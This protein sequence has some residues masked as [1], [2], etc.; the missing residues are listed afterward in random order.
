MYI[1]IYLSLSLP[2]SAKLWYVQGFLT[3]AEQ[4]RP[5]ITVVLSGCN[6]LNCFPCVTILLLLSPILSLEVFHSTMILTKCN[7]TTL[8]S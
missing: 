8:L 6:C 4:K 5:K 7:T 1:Y 3:T 2:P